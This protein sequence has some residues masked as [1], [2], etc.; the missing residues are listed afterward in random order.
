MIEEKTLKWVD[1][2]DWAHDRW[3]LIYEE[4]ERVVATIEKYTSYSPKSNLWYF[5]R[6]GKTETF[7]TKEAAMK[8]AEEIVKTPVLKLNYP[9]QYDYTMTTEIFRP[10]CPQ[11]KGSGLYLCLDDCSGFYG[12]TIKCS[13]CNGT[14]V[15]ND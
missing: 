15:K 14:G 4:T 12:S 2:S 5:Y 3:I 7:L 8:Y 13:R 6:E 1:H 9:F 11:C 10:A